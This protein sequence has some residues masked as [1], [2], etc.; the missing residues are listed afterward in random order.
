V[1]R[2]LAQKGSP[3]AATTQQMPPERDSSTA[4]P[5]HFP[6]GSAAAR[7]LADGRIYLVS[8]S[9]AAGYAVEEAARGPARTATL[10]LE[11]DDGD[12][13]AVL[14]CAAGRPVAGSDEDGE[15][16]EDSE[17]GDDTAD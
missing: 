6:G 4:R 2:E 12:R 8:W 3:G 17:A 1:R 13:T 5:V 16:S 11:A 7:C 10:E 15:D 14:R 9:P